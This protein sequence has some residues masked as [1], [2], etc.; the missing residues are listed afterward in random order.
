LLVIYLSTVSSG[1]N[2]LAASVVEDYVKK[3]R[4]NWNDSQLAWV[5]KFIATATGFLSFGFVYIAEQMGN[6]F[7]VSFKIINHFHFIGLDLK[8]WIYLFIRQR[9]VY[10]EFLVHPRLVLVLILTFV[11][12]SSSQLLLLCAGFCLRNVLP[13]DQ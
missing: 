13:M 12:S 4:P 8:I 7:T 1:V 3:W 6:I 2:A 9:Q 10:S 5:S 11:I